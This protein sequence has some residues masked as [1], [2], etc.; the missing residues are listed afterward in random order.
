MT[1]TQHYSCV[2]TPKLLTDGNLPAG[3]HWA[4]WDEIWTSFG[5]TTWRRYL[6]AGFRAAV[7]SLKAS[8]CQTVFLDGSFVT[9]KEVPDDYDACWEVVGVDPT[10]LDPVLLTFDP[11]RATQKAKYLGELFIAS[12]IAD[13]NGR[14]F[15]EFFQI[16]KDTGSL[17]G[18]IALDLGGLT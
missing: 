2:V 6:L 9:E 3:I 13:S 12:D 5:C 15:F 1:L 4:S 14:A 18:I 16:D 8:G 7:D 10:L 17:K 11:G